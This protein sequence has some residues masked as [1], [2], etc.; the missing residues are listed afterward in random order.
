[1]ASRLTSTPDAWTREAAFD[2]C[3]RLARSHYENFTVGSWLIPRGLL[4]HMYAIYAYCRTVDD[5]GDE[6]TARSQGEPQ[7]QPEQAAQPDAVSRLAAFLPDGTGDSGPEDKSYRLALLDLWQSELES[8]YS[9]A[10][11]HPVMVALQ[12]TIECFD[13]PPQPFLKL[14]EANRMDQRNHRYPSYGDLLQYCVHSA[15]PV[16]HL[17]LG[18]FGYRD[19]ERKSLSD[20]T[21][22][23]LQL[24]NF[25]Q[26]VARDYRKGRIYIPLED[27]E[28]F[29][30]TEAEL[31]SGV[32]TPAF[33]QLMA[34]EVDRAMDLFRAGAPLASTLRGTVRLDVALF[35]RGG[36]AVLEAIRKQSYDVLT[37]RP[38]LSRARKA[39]LFLSTWAGWKLGLGFGLPKPR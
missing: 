11:A 27:L 17:V 15:N 12:E 22:T 2:Y 10:P 34:F 16:G 13:L 7:A 1:M 19:D 31:A 21:C 37:E 28:Y 36:V 30:Y 18:L 6:A 33:R 35:T 26:D 23:A 29:G 14:I 38:R 5:L 20:A 8:C 24:T 32:V 4:R 39:G 3:Q 9:G 25:W